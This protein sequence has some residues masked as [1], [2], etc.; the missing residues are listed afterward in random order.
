MKYKPILLYITIFTLLFSHIIKSNDISIKDKLREFTKKCLNQ[1]KDPGLGLSSLS[2]K[3]ILSYNA[4]IVPKGLD[5]NINSN[6]SEYYEYDIEALYKEQSN[7]ISKIISRHEV[8]KTKKKIKAYYK[9]SIDEYIITT[10]AINYI[11]FKAIEEKE[12]EL[13]KYLLLNYNS[14]NSILYSLLKDNYLQN[15][16]LIEKLK[17]TLLFL[18]CNS[19]PKVK[20]GLKDNWNDFLNIDNLIRLIK[21]LDK[22][23]IKEILIHSDADF[24][25][26]RIINNANISR[27]ENINFKDIEEATIKKELKNKIYELNSLSYL[28]FNNPDPQRLKKVALDKKITKY[29]KSKYSKKLAIYFRLRAY[30]TYM[31]L[32]VKYDSNQKNLPIE[33]ASQIS[34]YLSFS[35]MQNIIKPKEHYDFTYYLSYILKNGLIVSINNSI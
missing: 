15:L 21:N 24:L 32:N 5:N 22:K 26:K 3:E 6:R 14:L 13:A 10:K 7:L 25:I 1:L 9:T 30:L 28:F 17:I 2:L 35:D 4:I 18:E 29:I 12:L 27:L 19:N 34:S 11:F 20:C 23:N 8:N 33:I 31:L 16:N